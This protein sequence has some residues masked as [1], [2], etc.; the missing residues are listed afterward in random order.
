MKKILF[1]ALIVLLFGCEKDTSEPASECWECITD[2]KKELCD[3]SQY[4][5][6]LY[7]LLQKQ[8]AINKLY[9]ATMTDERRRQELSLIETKYKCTKK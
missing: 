2:A 3:V 8:N 7:L 1:I 6:D 5:V 4:E 9:T